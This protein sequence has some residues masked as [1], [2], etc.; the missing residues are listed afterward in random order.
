MF[1]P[2]WRAFN[3]AEINPDLEFRTISVPQLSEEKVSWA[4]YWV[5]GVSKSSKNSQAAWDFLKFLTSNQSLQRLYEQEKKLRLFGEPPPRV[6]LASQLED[7]P[8]VGAF[9][10]QAEFAQSWYAASRTFDN[11]INDRIIKYL[12]DAVNTSLQKG[13]K[14]KALQTAAAGIRQVLSVYGLVSPSY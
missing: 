5:E 13:D 2:S 3:I 4:T 14:T 7:D 11:G 9:V 6:S 8:L 1:A 10:N 12:E